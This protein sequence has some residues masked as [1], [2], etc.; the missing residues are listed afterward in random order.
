MVTTTM[1]TTTK[2]STTRTKGRGSVVVLVA[3]AVAVGS[4]DDVTTTTADGPDRRGQQKNGDHSIA[5]AAAVAAVPPRTGN[6]ILDAEITLERLDAF[7]RHGTD[8][9]TRISHTDEVDPYF[10]GRFTYETSLDVALDDVVGR[11]YADSPQEDYNLLRHNGAIYSLALSYERS[12]SRGGSGSG[13]SG[14]GGTDNNNDAVIAAMQRAVAYLKH[15]TLPVPS[16][17]DGHNFLPDQLAPWERSDDKDPESTPRTAKLGGAGLALIAMGYMEHIVPGTTDTEYLRQVGNFIAALQNPDTGSFTCK[18]SYQKG[19]PDA[20][21][22]SLY[23]P[24]EAA[25]GMAVLA[26][27]E[28]PTSDLRDKWVSVGTKAL[29]YLEMLRRDQDLGDI[30]AD[31]WALL[32]TARILPLLLLDDS[33]STVDYWLVYSHGVR[34]A[35][36]MVAW[37]NNPPGRLIEHSGCFT[38]DRR[39]C[40]TATRLEGL[41]ECMLCIV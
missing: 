15:E 11:N 27:L 20:S 6:A 17:T 37:N 16:G 28:E 2:T 35:R 1:T 3:A 32:A 21:W 13:G 33:S 25:L 9:L 41:C 22:V 36:S 18:Y 40:P 26:E 29:L 4:V 7:I 23:Y 38:F 39:T 24:G 5:A 30:E 14:N 31:H 8:Y 34:V 19:A 12:R 10:P